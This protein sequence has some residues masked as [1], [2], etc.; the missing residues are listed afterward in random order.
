MPIADPMNRAMIIEW[1]KDNIN[2]MP[3]LFKSHLDLD[4][5]S[6]RDYEPPTPMEMPKEPKPTES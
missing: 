1:A 5:E 2:E 6:L 4:I 3:D